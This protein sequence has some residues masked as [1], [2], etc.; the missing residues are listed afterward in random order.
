[1]LGGLILLDIVNDDFGVAKIKVIG[2]GGGG[3][4]A[5]DR[6]V[7]EGVDGVEFVSVNTDKQALDR[8]GAGVKIQLG[9]KTTKG[10]GA[11]GRPEIGKQAAE[12]TKDDINQVLEGSDMVFVTAGMGG[13]T[14]TGAAPVVASIAKE[15][16]AL[17]IGVVT[18]PFDIEGRVR[19]KNAL[20]GIEELKKNVDALIIIPNE[21]LLSVVDESASFTD[22]FLKADEV[23]KQGVMGIS[24]LI[25]KPGQINL[26]Y[27]DICTVMKNKGL[28]HM[29]VG[30]GSGKNKVETAF[31]TAIN[32]PL[33]ETTISGA[34]KILI[35]IEGGFDLGLI[36]TANAVKSIKSKLDE[37]VEVFFGT[38][39]NEN[40]KDEVVVTVIATELANE[41]TLAEKFA[42]KTA[43][44]A[45]GIEKEPVTEVPKT[46]V[47]PVV[48]NKPAYTPTGNE[49]LDIPEFLRKN[50]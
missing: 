12:E 8:S 9:A 50:Y 24:N 22:A 47:T 29:G 32:F 11:G 40:L 5:V 14:G 33:L 20:E 35:N 45:S 36:E 26:D 1:M 19:M 46:E 4:N 37:G 48:E 23:L 39:I 15:A 30:K 7:E 3:N 49:R 17:T 28:A 10:L 41:E 38:T 13:G 43:E 25:T 18:K 2:V 42:K 21:K 6:M 16:G 44:I 31:D 34:R 27:N